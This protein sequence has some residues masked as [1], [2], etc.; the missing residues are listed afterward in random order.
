MSAQ[1][2]CTVATPS[3]KL[4]IMSWDMLSPAQKAPLGTVHEKVLLPGLLMIVNTLS[5]SE[6]SLCTHYVRPA[7]ETE[8][9]DRNR[10]ATVCDFIMD[11]RM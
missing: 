11:K 9:M 6:G 10:E 1:Q 4:I 7:F 5:A 8:A 3:L 2:S